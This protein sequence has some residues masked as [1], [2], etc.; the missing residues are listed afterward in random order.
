MPSATD[1][2]F[3]KKFSSYFAGL[4]EFNDVLNAAG[5]S[6]SGGDHE[7]EIAILKG[8]CGAPKT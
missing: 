3:G 2:Q 1:E 7:T 5:F 8:R 4:A 6:M